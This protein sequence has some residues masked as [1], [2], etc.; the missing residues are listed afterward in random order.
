MDTVF[1]RSGVK[2]APVCRYLRTFTLW[3]FASIRGL[4]IFGSCL[5]CFC[6]SFP[7]I[8]SGF[9]TTSIFRNALSP[10]GRRKQ[11]WTAFLLVSFLHSYYLFQIIKLSS[12]LIFQRKRSHV[13]AVHAQD[14]EWAH[15]RVQER[16]GRAVCDTL[17][18]FSYELPSN[19]KLFN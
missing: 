13:W 9:W 12:W 1:F 19:I 15:S 7:S 10:S 4:S 17:S 18:Y 11:K 2:R 14:A 16:V 3:I 8:R 5:G 6:C